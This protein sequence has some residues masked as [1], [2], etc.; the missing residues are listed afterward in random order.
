M[1]KTLYDLALDYLNQGMPDITQAPRTTSQATTSSGTTTNP[2]DYFNLP[3]INTLPSPSD[4][5]GIT[6]IPNNI[7]NTPQPGNTAEQ[8][9]LIDEGIGLQIEPGSPISSIYAVSYTHSDAADE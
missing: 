2:T 4:D 3:V 1:A 6:S 5:G 9:R 7:T 8:Q